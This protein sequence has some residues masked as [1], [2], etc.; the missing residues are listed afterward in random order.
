MVK[1][2]NRIL[3]ALVIVLGFF[4]VIAVVNYLFTDT[5][6]QDGMYI[7]Y[8]GVTYGS[9]D[10]ADGITISYSETVTFT[11]GNTDGWGNYSVEDCTV[12]IVPNLDDDHNFEFTVSGNHKSSV[13]SSVRDVTAAFSV[14]GDSI[15]VSSS[16]EFSILISSCDMADILGAVYGELE[17][18]DGDYYIY[19]YPYIA[20]SV[21]S[22]DGSDTITIPLIVDIDSIVVERLEFDV[23][24]I[25][26]L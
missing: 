25:I 17:A 11:I 12:Q 24:G 2:L 14:D 18:I 15:A 6:G 22:P 19:D 4:G 5:Q 7:E 9:A 13:Y 20:I 3:I 8:A 26:L 16:G 23:E 21:T 10:S 1:I